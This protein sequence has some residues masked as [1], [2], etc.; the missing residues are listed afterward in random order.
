[1]SG[2]K[3]LRDTSTRS[4]L[5]P[6]PI[7]QQIYDPIRNPLIQR[8]HFISK[9]AVEISFLPSL[10]LFYIH[11]SKFISLYLTYNLISLFRE[12]DYFFWDILFY[13]MCISCLKIVIFFQA[14]HLSLVHLIFLS[15]S[16]AVIGCISNIFLQ[17]L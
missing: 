3:S 4:H 10:I 5:Y 8:L 6:F 14:I 15:R 11:F 2:V 13:L 12:G 16:D 1:M 9:V 7:L 17:F